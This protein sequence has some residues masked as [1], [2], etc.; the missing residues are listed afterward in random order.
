MIILNFSQTFWGRE[1]HGLRNKLQAKLPGILLWAIEGWARLRER[2]KF[3]QPASAQ[4][5]VED[6]HEYSS[7]AG[8]F[9]K[10]C[11]E[12]DPGKSLNKGELYEAFANW[13][14]A[15]GQAPTP[16]NVFCRN[17]YAASSAL[18]KGRDVMHGVAL[19]PHVALQLRNAAQRMS[20]WAAGTAD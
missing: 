9:V 7:A 16:M 12:L 6:L 14:R 2:G 18:R 20:G 15:N 4:T 11:C 3:M 10:E 1:D 19:Q 5:L 17:L 13:C 8:A